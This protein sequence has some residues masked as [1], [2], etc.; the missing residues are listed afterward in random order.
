MMVNERAIRESNLELLRIISMI[1]IVAHH[2]VVNSGLMDIIRLN[3]ANISSVFL[4]VF[5]WGV[6]QQ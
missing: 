1:V 4:L 2:Y 6:R 3:P 5:G